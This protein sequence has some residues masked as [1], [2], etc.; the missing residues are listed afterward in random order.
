MKHP[1]FLRCMSMA[2]ALILVAAALPF[3]AL[4]AEADIQE[5]VATD[6]TLDETRFEYTGEEIRPN[7]T[8]RVKDQL[9]TLDK[10]YTLAYKNN[11]EVGT[12]AVVVT[13][14]ATS[15]YMGTVEHPFYIEAKTQDTPA[16]ITIKGTDVTID[17]TSFPATGQEIKPAVTVT[18]EG[19]TLTAGQEYTL[20]YE[21]NIQPGTASVTVT[22]VE[23][24][25]Y[26][27]TVIIH[28]TIE[29]APEETKPEETKPE[30]TQPEETKPEETKPE[31]TKPE[32]TKPVSYKITKGNGA[33]WHKNSGKDL[34]FTADGNHKDFTAILV[35]GKKVSNSYYTVAEGT[36]VTLNSKLLQSLDLGKH[37][38]VLQFADG[39]A[40]GT[41]TVSAATDTENPKTG[42]N[43]ALHAWTALLFV[44]LTGIIGVGFACRKKF[45]K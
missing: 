22:G 3:G 13:G 36:V 16:P 15:G 7:V 24:K 33:A 44:S 43:F 17:G 40:S 34:S 9:L 25:G 31:E 45:R 29:K 32:E 18:V 23:D 11:V 35:D 1:N 20:A 5:L 39:E 30:E 12:A 6:V 2:L 19:K 26:T 42:D 27:G 14:I 37:T 38:V 8:V 28:Y 21:N 10:D 41:F 4:A